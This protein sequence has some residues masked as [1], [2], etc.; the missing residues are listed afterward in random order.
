MPHVFKEPKAISL[1]DIITSRGAYVSMK[2][3]SAT[4]V[5]YSIR[6]IVEEPAFCHLSQY[7]EHDFFL[8]YIFLA[9][10]NYS[11]GEV[12]EMQIE[13]YR[14]LGAAYDDTPLYVMRVMP[15]ESTV[16]FAPEVFSVGFQNVVKRL[17]QCLR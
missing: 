8:L 11:E 4:D 5:L 15:L 9:F 13:I 7:L 14:I 3:K 12:V 6:S 1:I 17:K 2:S 10:S 16:E